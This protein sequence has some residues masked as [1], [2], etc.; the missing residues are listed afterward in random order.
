M[1]DVTL[2]PLSWIRA[3]AAGFAAL[4][5]AAFMFGRCSNPGLMPLPPRTQA[6]AD[7]HAAASTADTVNVH[8]LERVAAELSKHAARDSI[9]R[10]RAET[11]ARVSSARADSLAAQA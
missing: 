6:L 4:I 9:A 10:V 2:V 8:R 1:N 5:F 11:S 7:R 3:A